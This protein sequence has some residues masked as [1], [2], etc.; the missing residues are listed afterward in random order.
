MNIP[1]LLIVNDELFAEKAMR[2]KGKDVI[3]MKKG[4]IPYKQ[5]IMKLKEML[6]KS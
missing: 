2:I 5:V 1:L 3:L 6:T 4:K